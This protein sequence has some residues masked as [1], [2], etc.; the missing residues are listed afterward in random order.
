MPHFASG[1]LLLCIK[2]GIYPDSE[3]ALQPSGASNPGF[4]CRRQPHV[5]NN[6]SYA[7]ISIR[8]KDARTPPR[9]RKGFVFFH[10]RM[11]L[12]YEQVELKW[13]VGS[14]K[15]TILRKAFLALY[16]PVELASQ[17]LGHMRSFLQRLTGKIYSCISRL[18]RD[19]NYIKLLSLKSKKFLR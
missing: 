12:K 7:L 18:F 19:Y 6:Q 8:L 3:V 16:L 5:H 4:F 1:T 11:L 17:L 13:E 10:H 14:F 2:P 9:T 15:E